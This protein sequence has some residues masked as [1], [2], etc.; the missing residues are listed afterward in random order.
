MPKAGQT[1]KVS[2]TQRLSR[3]G[4]NY[5][6]PYVDN[7]DSMSIRYGNPGLKS[8]VS[9]SFEAGYTYFKPKFNFSATS[10]ASMVNN[11]IEP[12]SSIEN[13]GAT[14]TTYENIGRNQRY[15][16]GIY[17]SFRPSAKLNVNFNGNGSYSRL[18]ANGDYTINNE[19]FY[20]GFS[21]GGRL[22]LW[23]NGSASFNGGFYSPQIQLQGKSSAY[24]YT[25]LGVSQ[26]LLKRKLM[27]SVSLRD[28]FWYRK[29]Y[30]TK[31]NDI[32][33]WTQNEVSQLARIVRFNLTY[34]FGQMKS[35]VKKAKR[36]IKNDDLK[37]NDN[38]QEAGKE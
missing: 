26:F 9:H 24:Y 36:G 12:I 22:T 25:S 27:L 16:L 30:I 35:E 4:I 28:P 18:E 13:N 10:F 14:T 29:Q 15:G 23:E 32:T 7:T 37:P 6:N 1:I 11:S 2:Y 17:L 5:L 33:F 19:G 31:K 20:Y 3:P 21:L 34:N 8:E 38:N